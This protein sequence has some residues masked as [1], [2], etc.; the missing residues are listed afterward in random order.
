[1]V[2]SWLDMAVALVVIGGAFRGYKRG[3]VREGM[4]FLGLLGGMAL[5]AR[6]HSDAAGALRP[7]VGGGAL[8]DGI[9]YL[10]IVLITLGC[11]TLLTLAIRKLMHILFVGWLDGTAGALFGAGQGAVVAA[12]GL[13]LL[14]KFQLF[15]LD[16]VV[17]GSD[18]AML[19][20]GVLPGAMGFL[21]P[22]LGSVAHFFELPKQP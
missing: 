13:F 7:F 11:A 18:L 20:L 22:E 16:K 8:A 6:W 19:I 1:M 14:V 4:A 15:G 9:A 5:A 12:L 21:P 17:K 10:G 2:P 3:L